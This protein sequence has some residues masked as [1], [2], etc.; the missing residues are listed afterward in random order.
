MGDKMDKEWLVGV[1]LGGTTTKLAI[2]TVAGEIINKW[3][4]VTDTG[5]EGKNIIKNIAISI[6]DKINELGKTKERIK[7][8]GIG[9]PGPVNL[10]TG[11]VYNAVNLGWKENYPLKELLEEEIGL[12]VKADNDANCAAL[13]EMWKGSGAGAENLVCITIGTGVGGGVIVDGK[14]VQGVKG[15][16]GEIG[17]MTVVA[18]GGAPC[19]CGKSGCLETIV[20]ATGIVRQVMEKLSN[21]KN[22]AGELVNKYQLT[23]K[24]TAKDV[25]DA[26]RNGD[27]LALSIIE[28]TAV[29]LGLA[30]ASIGNILN[31]EKIVIGG[32]VS[33]AGDILMQ[34]VLNNFKEFAF[35]SVA[36]S[37]TIVPASLGNDAGIYGA[38]W[39]VK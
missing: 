13:G 6:E 27:S 23:R 12:L 5:N 24:I 39:L 25:F 11:V 16:A 17:H 21:E 32:G 3:E 28:H 20:S 8:I 33:K 36:Q 2:M 26:G 9:T 29:H 37:T 35:S 15:A 30:L 38:A 19:N 7:G 14:I 1:D 31:P 34:P 4:I 10:T 22:L 18:D